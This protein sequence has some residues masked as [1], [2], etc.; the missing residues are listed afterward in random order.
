LA[1][2]NFIMGAFWLEELIGNELSGDR[3]GRKARA[4]AVTIIAQSDRSGTRTF[5]FPWLVSI[6]VVV[7]EW[8]IRPC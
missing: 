8:R 4:T 2:F 1:H 3:G 6:L 7:S 5:S